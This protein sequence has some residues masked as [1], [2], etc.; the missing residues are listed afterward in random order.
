MKKFCTSL[1]EHA[2]NIT[3]FER[4]KILPLTKKV[5]KS[6]QDTEV[7]CIRGKRFMKKLVKDKHHPQ[8]RN[9]GHYTGKYRGAAHTICNLRFNLPYKT[10]V[11]SH[12]GSNYDYRF[13]IKELA[14]GLEGQFECL[15][16]NTKN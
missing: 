16:E 2:K 7:C 6:Q 10:P 15:G 8:V 1:R 11:V 12:N 5:I 14:K 9:H 3:D 4:N 13:I